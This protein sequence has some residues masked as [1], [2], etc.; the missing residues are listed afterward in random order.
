MVP[1]G[2]SSRLRILLEPGQRVHLDQLWC[3]VLTL[4]PMPKAYAPWHLG[5]SQG[6]EPNS[7]E[8]EGY[9]AQQG[10]PAPQVS[11]SP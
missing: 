7:V 1:V 5:P 10:A 4:Y 6:G 11:A 2:A 9:P 3:R 8:R